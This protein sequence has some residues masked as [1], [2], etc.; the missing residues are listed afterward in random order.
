M[1]PNEENP[2]ESCSQQQPCP[3]WAWVQVQIPGPLT[4]S[5]LGIS[6]EKGS[7]PHAGWGRREGGHRRGLGAPHHGGGMQQELTGLVDHL[8]RQGRHQPRA[9][10]L[11]AAATG[12]LEQEGREASAQICQAKTGLSPKNNR[13]KALPV[14][15][16]DPALQGA[17]TSSQE[18]QDPSAPPHRQLP[19]G[20]FPFKYGFP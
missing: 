18:E 2:C 14:A 9:G 12:H 8:Y 17:T 6:K 15:P 16:G 19:P 7:T 20:L 1:H 3:Q 11:I 5:L 4:P 10:A 13:G